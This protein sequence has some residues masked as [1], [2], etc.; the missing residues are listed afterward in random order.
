MPVRLS[1]RQVREAI[2][3]RQG[4]TER[5]GAGRRTLPLLGELF[6]ETFRWLVGADA[7]PA[8]SLSQ[9]PNGD[10]RDMADTLVELA[11]RRVIGPKLSNYRRALDEQTTEVLD[12]WAAVRNLCQW[13]AELL[14][15]LRSHSGDDPSSL[16]QRMQQLAA[17]EMRLTWEIAQ[18]EWR[19]SVV[20]EGI[21]DAVLQVPGTGRWCVIELKLG[22]TSPE[23]D[24]AQAC[25]Y[26][27]M[28]QA[29]EWIET[30]A[31][32]T[33]S[34]A[35]EGRH[36]LGQTGTLALVSFTP[37]RQEHLIAAEG[38]AAAQKTLTDLIGRLAGVIPKERLYWAAD[39][40]LV[41]PTDSPRESAGRAGS[42]TEPPLRVAQSCEAYQD[43][44]RRLIEALREH[45]LS[46]ELHGDPIVGP[47]F[48][49]FALR[50]G[51][52]VRVRQ[53]EQRASEIQL[54]LGLDVAPFL[55]VG[56][57]DVLVDLPR[58]DRQT[59]VLADV[60]NQLPE[61][62][63]VQG[64]SKLLLGVDLNGQL[65][66]GDLSEPENAHF[67]VAGTTGSG[68]TEWLRTAIA[69]LMLTNTRETLQLLLIDP[70]RNG[71]PFLKDSPFL[72]RPIVYLDEQDPVEVLE[73]LA[74]EM[75]RRYRR[76]GGADSLAEHVRKEGTPLPRIACFCDEFAD[77]VTVDAKQRK[78]VE[79]VICRLG[80]KARAAGI[81]LILATQQPSRQVVTGAL[82]TN[83]PARVAL[84]TTQA[85]ESRML[86]DEGGAERLLGLGDLLF[87][88]IGRPRRLQG[89]YLPE[90][91]RSSLC[92]LA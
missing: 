91:E 72:W 75:E 29:A 17:I 1:V 58:P 40:T 5:A 53:I 28:L 30:P 79:Q 92:G 62:A 31:A 16:R 24:L 89:V 51:R 87:K 64:C 66:F 63:P 82:K 57:G 44:G 38:L 85:I 13:L 14:E 71:F 73:E 55:S 35:K 6:H 74:Q 43:L 20:V 70:K 21:A 83:L 52:G 54:R 86:L 4:T 22:Q 9:R 78:A 37:K 84:R 77:L 8:E 76:M 65:R 33:D 46:V 15:T 88:D 59:V 36:G 81:H 18:P 60:R 90:H 2:W 19:D 25:L 7:L 42:V 10:T 41:S 49:R 80:Q 27:A 68:K 48:L 47:T 26:H 3:L 12:F 32:E 67:L 50:P 61:P 69:S 39:G 34:P 23:A 56:E 45:G 11:Y